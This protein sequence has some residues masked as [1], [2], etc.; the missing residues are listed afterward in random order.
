PQ[1]P[2]SHPALNPIWEL[3]GGILLFFGWAVSVIDYPEQAFVVS[4]LALW[5]VN[6][7]LQRYS[8]HADLA[9]LFAIGLQSIWL[10][11]R[12][13]PP[14]MQKWS[15]AIATN[16]TQAQNEPWALL[17]VALFP[18]LIF[19]VWLCDR[20]RHAE[21]RDLA[22]FGEALALLFGTSLT[23]IATINP[24]L[25]SLN[26]VF[27][28]IT[29]VVVTKRRSPSSTPLIYLTHF[30]GILSLFS[31][32]NLLLP[33][34]PN[35]LWASVVLVVM[36]A[37]WG[38]SLG[39]GI[40]RR[41]AW[42]IGLGLSILSFFLLWVNLISS[43]GV[44]AN[45]EHWG[46]IW[47]IT[48]LSLTFL[49]NRTATQRRTTRSFL[50][51]L[52]VAMAQ[53]LTIS[54]PGTRLIGLAVGASVMYTNT[55]Y[56]RNQPTAGFTIGLGLSLLA[57]LLWEGIPGLPNLTIAGWLVVGAIATFSLWLMR[58]VF[59]QRNH[60]LA[61][62]YAEASDKWAIALCCAVLS[63]LTIHSYLVYDAVVAP[64][65]W[66]LVASAVTLAAITYR[67][68]REPTNWAFYGIAW[69]VE[70]F[71]AEV[72]GFGERSIIRVAIANIALG[73]FTQLLGEWWRRRYHPE[74]LPSSL[75]ILPLIYGA[76]SVLLRLN[77]FTEW[78]G[79]FT[80]G[81]ALIVIGVGRRHPDFKPLLYFGIIGVSIS[82][83]ELLFYQMSQATGG[84]FG[85][86][87]IAMSALGTS[88][89]LVYSRLSPWLSQYL[90]LSLAEIKGIAHLHWAWSSVLLMA[91]I[92]LPIQNN[93]LVGLGTGGLLVM[94][95]IF[96]GRRSA[97][98]PL[99]ELP[100]VF[101]RI[102]IQEMWVYLGL[103]QAAG[104]RV[105]WRETAVGDLLAGTLLPWNAAIACLIAYFLYSLPWEN[106]G[107]SKKP[108]Q[109]AAYI[110]PLIILWETRLQV[111]PI[112][113]LIAAGFYIILAKVS[114]NIRVT[115]ISIVLIDWALFNWLYQL[116]ITDALW[117][118][119]ATGLSLLYIAQVDPQL[120]LPEYKAPRHILR[121][122]G[123][124]VIC[125]WA[126][127]FHQNT[128]FIPGIFSLIAIFAGLALRIR[129]FLYVG[130]ATFLITG[131]YQLVIFSLRYP[132]LKWFV[133]LLVGIL[134][135]YIAAN[136]ETHRT[137]INSL[138]RNRSDEFQEWQ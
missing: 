19:I 6:Q 46:V 44:T 72:L 90:R 27:S 51:I 122:V 45:Q 92:T 74:R 100:G 10:G 71:I 67:S 81:V 66:Y 34:L 62:I 70:L 108:W 120:R 32:I 59:Q 20:L 75:H 136:F 99:P 26:L 103:L 133:G 87:L 37:E 28:T 104:M 56:L 43:Y 52:A 110:L 132:F 41:S 102:T 4:G 33:N 82:A 89:M 126:V 35:H 129:A 109:L 18:Y 124:G 131:I 8:L 54:L 57:A 76:F 128:V 53:F 85:D 94:Y 48:P 5:Y 80:L 119:T 16:L 106:W 23:T 12:L 39:S 118:V 101:G 42:H 127:L 63:T 117:Q 114:Q 30:I 29:L 116:N 115:Y 98:S 11:W 2:A 25:R 138:L 14:G 13:V 21:K 97:N 88:I 105:Y 55:R 134:L 86:G 49:A 24:T 135:I 3:L 83:Y 113:L 31:V 96:Q 60:E 50:S 22:N 121:L 111:Y 84:G 58:K 1:P 17:S 77:T 61:G 47:L 137:Q 36:V 68:W 78:T 69:C 38:F 9:A 130:T 40:W 107:W 112:T 93:R 91:A 123:S 7:R 95:A 65:L 125:G 64:G 79:L 15:I 73:L